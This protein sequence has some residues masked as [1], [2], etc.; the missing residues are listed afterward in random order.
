MGNVFTKS[1]NFKSEYSCAVVRVGELTPV[2]GSDF[3]AKTS[4]FGTQI[5]VRKDEIKEGDVMIYAANETAL[6]EDF[7]SVNNLYEIG[8]REKNAN[9]DEVN[10]I[11]KAY[12]PIKAKADKYRNE[13]K[14]LKS[15]IDKLTN[16]AAKMTKKVNSKR[17]KLSNMKEGTDEYVILQNEIDALVK[18]SEEATAKAMS[19]TT[20]YVNAKN[21]A[22][23][24]SDTGADIIAEAKKLCGFFNKYGR[25][26]CIILKGEPSF[27]FLFKPENLKLFDNTIM[28][29][30]VEDY[31]DQ[32]FDTVNG[33]LFV[34]AFVP[35]VKE[36]PERGSRASKAQKKVDRFNRLVEGEF[37]LHYETDQFQKMVTLFKPED[38]V[39]ITVKM[40]GTSIVIGKVHVKQPIRLPFFK[41]MFNFFV[42]KTGLF[43]SKRITDYEVVYGPVYSSRKVIKNKYINKDV[44]GGFYGTDIWTEYGD[45]IY[46]YLDE[47][48]T[49]YGE[50]CGYITD[51]DKP[52]QKTYDY[53]CN[54]GENIIMFYRITT[55][56]EDGSKCE[57]EVQE[58]FDWTMKLKQKLYDEG[59]PIDA[60]KIHPIDVLYHGTLEDLYPDL[61]EENHWAVNLLEKMKHDK[62]HFGMEENEPLCT[63]NKVPREGICIRKCGDKRPSCYKLKTSAFFLG[64]SI[65][66][67]A[68][69][70]DIEM[71]DNYGDET[72][73]V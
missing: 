58:V 12:E 49:V 28:L 33:V 39:D 20:E 55:T 4:V 72:E 69:E 57:W 17:A 50:I 43:K 35:P 45:M 3:L 26:R 9:V 29:S 40:H 65:R 18:K 62:E 7:L 2:E 21:K 8:C 47:G 19:L 44:N 63:H 61:D 22:K 52:I 10:E 30:D 14:Q 42:D 31:V 68:G 67:D 54:K 66:M 37:A 48:M 15:S 6:N 24:I 59:K 11:M 1:E 5:V 60:L 27:G 41:R 46:P 73:T 13:A 36:R 23:E 34:K 32:E 71:A 53:G 56:N 38:V 64:E 25:V 51:S 70:V 16:N